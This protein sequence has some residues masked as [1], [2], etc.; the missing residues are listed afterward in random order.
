VEVTSI[1]GLSPEDFFSIDYANTSITLLVTSGGFFSSGFTFN[2]MVLT[3]LTGPH[4]GTVSIGTNTL[5]GFATGRL[6]STS[7][8][9]SLNF[10]G[11]TFSTGQTLVLNVA[12]VAAP[13]PEP[14]TWILL[15]AGLA[16]LA[17][18]KKWIA[19]RR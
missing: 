8:S 9:I 13:T 2:G 12:D 4:I 14:S 6:S 1:P 15:S 11:L 10:D 5:A 3:D 19:P 16:V 17:T 7:S 18:K